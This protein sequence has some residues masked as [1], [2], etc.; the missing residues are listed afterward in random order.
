[1]IERVVHIKK[2]PYNLYIGRA[3]NR[4]TSKWGNPYRIGDPHP[5]TGEPITRDDSLTL[6]K[7]YILRGAGR[8]LLRDI[9]ELDN[10][11]LGCFCAPKGGVGIHDP[12]VCHGQILLELLEHRRKKTAER[13]AEWQAERSTKKL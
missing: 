7:H 9:G 5:D 13:Q 4:T 8:R 3:G 10:Q 2:D 11:I 1:M 6:F 12:L